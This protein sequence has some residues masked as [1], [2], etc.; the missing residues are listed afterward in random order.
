MAVNSIAAILFKHSNWRD[1]KQKYQF[2]ENAIDSRRVWVKSNGWTCCSILRTEGFTGGFDVSGQNSA[3]PSLCSDGANEES[4]SDEKIVEEWRK[5]ERK[6]RECCRKHF[7]MF[8]L[9]ALRPVL[10]IAPVPPFASVRRGKVGIIF[11]YSEPNKARHVVVS[12]Q[13]K[14]YLEGLRSS[15]FFN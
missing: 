6:R 3:A 11:I 12:G 10:I 4:W 1:I 7:W 2:Q 8:L 14:R 5:V 13:K 15:E 9:L